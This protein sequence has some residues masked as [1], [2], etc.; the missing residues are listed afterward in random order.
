[1]GPPSRATRSARCVGLYQLVFQLNL[2]IRARGDLP[3]HCLRSQVAGDWDFFLSPPSSQRS[4][5]GHLRPDNEEIQPPVLLDEVADTKRIHLGK[6][7][8]AMTAKDGS[9]TWTMIYDEAWEVNVDGVSFLAFSKYDLSFN[10]GVRSNISRCGESQLGWYHTVDRSLWGCFYAKK[11][12]PE[13]GQQNLLSYVPGPVAQT[14]AYDEPLSDQFHNSFAAGLNLLQDWW[15]A[16]PP[17]RR[18]TGKSLREMNLLAG[19]SRSLSISDHQVTPALPPSFLQ[20]SSVT[21]SG[22]SRLRGAMN[23]PLP[24][25]WDWRNASGVNYLDKVLDQGECG[26]CYAVATTRMLTSRHRIKTKDPRAE[27]FS[28]SFPLHCSEYNQGCNGGYAFLVSRWSQ[29]VGLVPKSCF[30]YKTNA[31]CQLTCDVNQ[32]GRRWRAENHHYVGGFYG[33]STEEEMIRELVHNGPLV[34]SFEPK[35]DIM[36]YTGGIYASVPNQRAEWE[37]V[38]HA[39]LLV[40][41]GEENG[42]KYWLL[43]NS[44]GPEW[45]ERGYFRMARGTDESGIES[46]VVA[47]DVVEDTAATSLLQFAET[48]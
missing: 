42:R 25:S 29:D 19:I 34:A 38:D 45:G 9:G 22:P 3:V 28:I 12:V 7:N 35:P 30:T 33:A 46:I 48:M 8:K 14:P 16:G 20:Q 4:S 47:A 5:C 26:A 39:V 43:Q 13:I 27:S 21:Q 2:I 18:F 15:Q 40:G 31:K 1:M 41:Y 17:H 10:G 24:R 36:Y 32:L 37:Q 6:P 23:A 44:W 11:A